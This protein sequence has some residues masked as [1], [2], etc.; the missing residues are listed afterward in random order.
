MRVQIDPT[1]EALRIPFGTPRPV[2]FHDAELDLDLTVRARG[3]AEIVPETGED[4]EEL[5][6]QTQKAAAEALR[7]QLE[8]NSWTWSDLE[9]RRESLEEAMEEA[10]ARNGRKASLHFASI[11]PDEETVKAL[12]EKRSLL[13]GAS[14]PP[15]PADGPMYDGPGAWPTMDVG[16]F[17]RYLVGETPPAPGDRICPGCGN[18]EPFYANFCTQCGTRLPRG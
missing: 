4:P 6:R 17:G 5:R 2:C 13:S 7:A 12:R 1:E 10:L 9:K 3:F 14:L 8:T 16:G 18:A 11:V 15:P